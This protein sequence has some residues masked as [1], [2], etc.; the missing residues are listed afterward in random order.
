[1]NDKCHIPWPRRKATLAP[2]TG[3]PLQACFIKARNY[4]SK[5]RMAGGCAVRIDLT[6][7]VSRQA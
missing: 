2:M 3:R 6:G 5:I 4:R 1:M 7:A